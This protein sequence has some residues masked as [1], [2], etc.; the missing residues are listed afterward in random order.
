MLYNRS[1]ELTRLAW[2]RLYASW[3]SA[4]RLCCSCHL[5][6]SEERSGS[7]WKDKPHFSCPLSC[8]L[9]PCPGTGTFSRQKRSKMSW[10]DCLRDLK[11]LI[12]FFNMFDSIFSSRRNNKKIACLSSFSY[13]SI[14]ICLCVYMHT[15][16]YVCI[17][18]TNYLK[19]KQL[20]APNIHYCTVSQ[21]REPGSSLAGGSGSRYSWACG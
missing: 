9:P 19:T 10:H 18:V 8:P 5:F 7:S 20:K 4:L 13:I 21:N 12:Q 15:F 2:L 14:Y 17:Y 1:L 16:M 6:C 11:F 3:F